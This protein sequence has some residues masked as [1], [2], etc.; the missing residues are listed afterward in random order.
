[1]EAQHNDNATLRSNYLSYIN[2]LQKAGKEEEAKA[3]LEAANKE[4]EKA[5]SPPLKISRTRLE[6]Q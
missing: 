3:F 2:E 1:M 4:L 5:G 6:K